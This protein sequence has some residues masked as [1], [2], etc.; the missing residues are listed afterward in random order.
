MTE[1]VKGRLKINRDES[2]LAAHMGPTRERRR[3]DSSGKTSPTYYLVFDES[4]S[5]L[6]LF[7]S[8]NYQVYDPI[9]LNRRCCPS[10]KRT[11]VTETDNQ[12][13]ILYSSGHPR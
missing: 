12:H 13:R 11:K 3:V 1:G 5:L 4:P 2:S 8:R 9:D 7:G 6:V 10:R